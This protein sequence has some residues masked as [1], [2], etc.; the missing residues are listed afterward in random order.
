MNALHLLRIRIGTSFLAATA[1]LLSASAAHAQAGE[2]AMAGMGR[3]VRG[4]VTAVAPDHL[5]VKT[6]AGDTYQVST[7]ANTRL[8]KGREPIKFADVHIGDGVGAMGEIDQP[9]KTVHALFIGVMDAE[10]IKKA[11]EAMGKTFI[12]G[13][14][15]AIDEL[16]L[17]VLRADGVT[18]VIEV[19]EGTSFKKGGR[20]MQMMMNPSGA[21]PTP[22]TSPTGGESITLADIKVG[23]NVAGP[24]ALKSGT[25]IPTQLMVADPA[26]QGG[27][28][29]RQ[30]EATGAA[31]PPAEP[32]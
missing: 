28:R 13:K 27:R 11:R 31:T 7:S 10:Q 17:T 24:G 18:Q 1:L 22:T 26:V 8:T 25:F 6:E 9:N 32:K 30:A 29:R 3:M 16:K 2:P 12:A 23:D 4:T 14:V 19:D 15:T 21:T 20:G 5:T